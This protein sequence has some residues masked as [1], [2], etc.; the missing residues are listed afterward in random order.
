MT[1]DDGQKATGQKDMGQ[2]DGPETAAQDNQPRMSKPY[3][4][5]D[6]P[7]EG[8]AEALAKELAEARDRTLRTL[9]EMENLRKRTTREIA[10]ARTFGISA[11]ARDVLDIEIARLLDLGITVKYDTRV[12]DLTT[13]MREGRFDAAFLAIGAQLSH[14]A[15]IPAG[16]AARGVA[17]AGQEEHA[18]H[19]AGEALQRLERRRQGQAVV[20]G[21][22][23]VAERHLQ[24]QAHLVQRRAQLVRELG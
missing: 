11:F 4:M 3:I 8:S 19:A 2:Q 10:D 15:Y 5:P 1:E 18:V 14:R 6:D 24:L 16:Q 23:L 12:T 17:L 20:L 21:R 9:A 22:P 7:E 13:T